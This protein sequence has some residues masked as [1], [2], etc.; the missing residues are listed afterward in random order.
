MRNTNKEKFRYTLYSVLYTLST[1]ELKNKFLQK[2]LKY[3]NKL[4]SKETMITIEELRAKGRNRQLNYSFD[5]ELAS[6]VSFQTLNKIKEN[7]IKRKIRKG[8]KIRVCFLIDNYSKLS[9]IPVYEKMQNSK[10]F[11]PF[12]L[13]YYDQDGLIKDQ[14]FES[15]FINIKNTYERFKEKGYNAYWGYDEDRNYIPIDNF[16]PDI[17]F[18][19]APYLDYANT[20]LTNIYLNINYLVCYMNYGLNTDNTYDYHR[21]NKTIASSWKHFVETREDYQEII[22][23]SKY[24]GSN[25][26]LVGY[27]KMD[28]YAKPIENCV[29]PAK[30][31]NG[32]PIVIYAPHWTITHAENCCDLSTFHIYYKYFLDVLKNNPNINFVF[33]PHPNLLSAVVHNKLMSAEEYKKYIEEWNN[34]D[35]GIVVESGE[36]IDLFRKSDLLIT[37]CGSFIGEWLPSNKPCMYLVKPT[38]GSKSFMNK[39]SLLGQKILEKYYLCHNKN[40]I[41]KYFGMIIN[42]KKDIMREERIKLKDE[43][44]INIG[45]SGQKIV[46]YL[47]EILAD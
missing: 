1:G 16:K 44:F 46:E 17:I 28:G 34:S 45:S 29:I 27:P 11:E 19:S 22:K 32:K 5:D 10:I 6:V 23:Y 38:K 3:K 37:D 41:K 8:Q 39:Y 35:N 21:N 7:D 14:M 9:I 15:L 30:I 20:Y 31:D 47:E 2:K 43:L 4:N 42:D 24:Y 40:D 13:V 18:T 26:V 36:Y 12:I 25:A 33:K